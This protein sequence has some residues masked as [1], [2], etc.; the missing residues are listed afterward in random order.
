MCDELNADSVMMSF[1]VD[2]VL[3]LLTSKKGAYSS[4]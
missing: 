3:C 2:F 4:S 1:V